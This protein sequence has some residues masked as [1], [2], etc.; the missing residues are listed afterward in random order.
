MM[1]PCTP[2]GRSCVAFQK[3]DRVISPICE[4][5]TGFSP[6]LSTSK[7]R[8]KVIR[9]RAL[10]GTFDG[11]HLVR[12]RVDGFGKICVGGTSGE[13]PRTKGKSRLKSVLPLSTKS[14]YNGNP[15]A[16]GGSCET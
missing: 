8:S 13:N 14:G 16:I 1:V 5:A 12:H 6:R 7:P 4:G 10:R 11:V 15:I 9:H 2:A 3:S